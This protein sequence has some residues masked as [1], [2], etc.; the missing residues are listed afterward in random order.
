[1]HTGIFTVLAAAVGWMSQNS[2]L[3]HS[4]FPRQQ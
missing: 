2:S 3:V 4:T 1:M